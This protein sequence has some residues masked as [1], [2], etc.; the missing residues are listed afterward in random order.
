MGVYVDQARNRLGRMVMCH[1]WAD[2]AAELHAMA[3]QVGLQRKWFQTPGGAYPSSFPHY[4][5]SQT[6]R[7]AALAEGAVELDRMAGHRSRTAIRKKIV[8]DPVFAG[9]WHYEAA[10][11]DQ[12][13]D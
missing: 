7:R 10:I 5:V 6:R 11:K 9:T 1:M 13:H 2:T 4:D 12:P 8:A 3:S